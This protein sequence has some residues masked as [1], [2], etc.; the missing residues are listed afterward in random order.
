M[1][2][3]RLSLYT[4]FIGTAATAAMATRG[5]VAAYT[6]HNS[7]E[8]AWENATSFSAVQDLYEYAPTHKPTKKPTTHK[9]TT[10]KPTKYPTTHKPIKSP[11]VY[12]RPTTN[13]PTIFITN[14]PTTR[15]PTPAHTK[16][17]KLGL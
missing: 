14:K 9:P 8:L 16:K 7:R 6:G 2:I 11:T 1:I 10:E 12:H 5:S 17:H 3:M 13:M 15:K 4:L